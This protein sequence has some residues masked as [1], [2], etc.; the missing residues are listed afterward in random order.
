MARPAVKGEIRGRGGEMAEVLL[1]EC[2]QRRAAVRGVRG[3]RG[4]T[5]QE[6]VAKGGSCKIRAG[7]CFGE[8][9]EWGRGPKSLFK[10]LLEVSWHRANAAATR[11]RLRSTA[12]MLALRHSAAAAPARP[13]F[14]A[15]RAAARRAAARRFAGRAAAASGATGL[16]FEY[17]ELELETAGPRISVHDIT[18]QIRAHVARLGVQEGALPSP[19]PQKIG[20]PQR[21]TTAA[22]PSINVFV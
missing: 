19:P 8:R 16:T 3:G 1:R 4:A 17:V 12:A 11:I 2:R 22:S 18:P 14:A 13:A 15:G 5:D 21:R 10:T 7:K 6:S 9:G 20:A